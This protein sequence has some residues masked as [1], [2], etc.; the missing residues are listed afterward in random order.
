MSDVTPEQKA[1]YLRARQA[2]LPEGVKNT[3]EELD[4]LAADTSQPRDLRDTCSA[5]ALMIRHYKHQSE[6]KEALLRHCDQHHQDD[7]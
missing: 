2:T 5:A 4:K 6:L 3:L 1:A 7:R